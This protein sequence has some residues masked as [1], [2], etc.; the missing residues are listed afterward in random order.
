MPVD[1]EIDFAALDL[2]RDDA[3]FD[4]QGGVTVDH[5]IEDLLFISD[6]WVKFTDMRGIQ[7]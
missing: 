7:Q 5:K 2:V 3:S 4:V 6:C 1:S